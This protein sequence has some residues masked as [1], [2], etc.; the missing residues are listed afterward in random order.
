MHRVAHRRYLTVGTGLA[1][2]G[3]ESARPAPANLF[4][5]ANI[6]KIDARLDLSSAGHEVLE[7][8]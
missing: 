2:V 3:V 8:P 5:L 4:G 1:A 7:S 6:E